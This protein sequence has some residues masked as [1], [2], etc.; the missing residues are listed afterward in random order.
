MLRA[1][2]ALPELVVGGKDI[3][4]GLST[5]RLSFTYTDSTSD[6][7][8][9]LSAEIA[10]PNRTWMKSVGADL[11]KGIQC[12]GRIVITDWM[13]PFD[14]RVLECG[15]FWIN[16]VGM[17]G[18]PN[19][20]SIKASS[21]P[22]DGIKGTK[23]HRSWESTDLKTIANQIAGEH[24][25][26][27]F[28]DTQKVSQK[29]KR[30]DQTDASDLEYLRNKCKD[31]ELSLKIH[32]KQLVIYSEEEYEA[33]PP[34]FEL[35]YGASS[36]LTYDFG[37]KSDDTFKKAKNSYVNP[38]TGKVTEQEHEA[39]SGHEGND[40]EL[41]SNVSPG[42]GPDTGGSFQIVQSASDLVAG[43]YFNDAAEANKGKG[44]KTGN[45]AKAK[46]RDKNKKENQSTFTVFGNI[47]YL[48]G[49]NCQTV[50]YGMFDKKWFIENSTHAISS[51]GYITTLKLRAALIGY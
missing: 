38:D 28:W 48:S 13:R 46:L 33:R 32:R 25:L 31:E 41:I 45:K 19:T 9:D 20:V 14:N 16:D 11:K 12:E 2:A 40:A 21:I 30:T 24:G 6:K 37:S 10:D 26:T 18:P 23:K 47:D 27:L 4:L 35:V 39:D 8:D 44:K 51:G 42:F 17:K 34:A 36:T 5:Q 50:D 15:I 3:L 43:D 29:V 1:R 7:A 22:P 49:L